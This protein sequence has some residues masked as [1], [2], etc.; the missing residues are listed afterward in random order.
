[1][2]LEETDR[3]FVLLGLA[4][5]S[6]DRPGFADYARRVAEKFDGLE[7]L[8]S[9]IRSNRDERKDIIDRA[10]KGIA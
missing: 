3:Q 6:L 10:F 1:V 8:E 4:V 2:D 7:M 9:F 5:L